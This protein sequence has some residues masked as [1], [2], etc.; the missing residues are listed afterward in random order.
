M[1]N[2][3]IWYCIINQ[4]PIGGGQLGCYRIIKAIPCIV[5]DIERIYRENIDLLNGQTTHYYPMFFHREPEDTPMKAAARAA[6]LALQAQED[7]FSW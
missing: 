3:P 7:T 6:H 4:E 2:T 5:G 1:E